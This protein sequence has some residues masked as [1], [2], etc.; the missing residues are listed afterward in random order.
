MY[1]IRR[2][3]ATDFSRFVDRFFNEA[4]GDYEE[5]SVT[6][7]PRVDVKENKDAYKIMADLPGMSKKDITISIDENVLTIKGERKTQEKQDDENC[8]C[9]ERTFGSFQRSLRLPNKVDDNKVKAEYKDGVLQ[10]IL[11]K[12]EEAK[13]RQ[14]EIQ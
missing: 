11:P 12:A 10:L 7:T 9:E 13:T 4:Y 8:Y 14:I 5:D 1:L 2:N 3:P 6:W